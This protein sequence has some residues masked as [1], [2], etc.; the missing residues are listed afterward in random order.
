M[1]LFKGKGS[2]H[3]SSGYSD[4]TLADLNGKHFGSFIRVAIYTA[5]CNLCGTTQYGSGLNA[6]ATDA[7]HLQVTQIFEVAKARRTSAGVLFIDL[8]SAFA[9]IARRIVIPSLPESQEA[10]IWH[11]V[12]CGFTSGDANNIVAGALSILD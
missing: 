10:W 5:V 6:G 8:D 11:L 12:S 7:C 4:I 2:K 3:L 9:M 1:E